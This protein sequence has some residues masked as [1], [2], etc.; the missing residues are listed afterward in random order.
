[1]LHQLRRYYL[2]KGIAAEG[3]ACPQG[4]PGVRSCRTISQDFVPA[5]EAFVGSEYEQGTLPRVLFLSIDASSAHP[6]R[7][8]SQRTL[9]YMRFW[10]ENG[11]TDPAGCD[12]DRL[13]KGRHWYWTHKI[14]YEILNNVACARLGGPIQF[15]HIHKY[16]AH[17]NSAKCKDAARGSGQGP[18]LVFHNCRP[19]LPGEVRLLRPDVIVTQGRWG[20]LAIEG[21]FPVVTRSS[22]PRYPQYQAEVLDIDGRQVLKFSTYHQNNHGGFNKE[23]SEAYP[24][25]YQV[26]HAFLGPAP[27][28]D[29]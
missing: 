8:P 16:F 10:E 15:R 1:M 24:W 5:R 6:G 26:A 28:K 17:T 19:F 9:E 3:F 2:D 7:A 21:A 18:D 29:A 14:A 13:H 25:Y 27:S 11:K 20:R 22:H 12:P 4:G 23:K